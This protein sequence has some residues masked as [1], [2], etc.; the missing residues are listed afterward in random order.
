MFLYQNIGF[1]ELLA[2]FNDNALTALC[3][4]V[5]ASHSEQKD[6]MINLITQMINNKEVRN[7]ILQ[8]EE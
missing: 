2:R 5:A 4:L 6:L 1:D 8:K 7:N 3:Y